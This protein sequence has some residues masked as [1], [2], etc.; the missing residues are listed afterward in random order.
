MKIVHFA[1][2]HIGVENYSRPDPET[3]LPSR[4]AD[5]LR[6]FDELVDFSLDDQVDMVLFAGDAYKS[7]DPSQTHQREFAKRIR[8]LTTAGISVFLLVGNHDLPNAISRA[9]AL[10]IFQ[11]LAVERVWVGSRI[12]T[13]V[14]ATRRCGSASTTLSRRSA[15]HSKGSR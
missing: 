13:T 11:T 7:R 9:S 4:L 10:E 3:G 15:R 1:D 14:V 5:F 12:G 6:A 8:R 2:L